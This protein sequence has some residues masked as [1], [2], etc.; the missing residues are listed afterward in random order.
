MV[1]NLSLK[2][3]AVQNKTSILEYKQTNK[4]KEKTVF[5]ICIL[6]INICNINI[7]SILKMEWKIQE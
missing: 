7:N 4:T 2:Q 3:N 5:L 6:N 1:K